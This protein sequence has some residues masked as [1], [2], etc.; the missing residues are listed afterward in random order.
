M[1]MVRHNVRR[2]RLTDLDVTTP[3]KQNIVAL[4]VTVNDVLGMQMR[5]TLASLRLRSTST[6]RTRKKK[7]S[8]MLTSK[9][10]VEI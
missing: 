1:A 2:V 9:H 6:L 8:R 10:T 4:D 5:Q 7:E 3:I